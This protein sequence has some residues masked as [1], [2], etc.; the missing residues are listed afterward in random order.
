[1]KRITTILFTTVMALTMCNS[2][3]LLS[4]THKSPPPPRHEA[5]PPHGRHDNPP[6][7]H[8]NRPPDGNR[9]DRPD[10]NRP[11]PP[12]GNN[13]GTHRRKTTRPNDF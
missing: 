10:D 11:T 8:D 1:M 6:P 4:D 12:Q 5:P 13:S 7:R 2:C 9:Y 3:M